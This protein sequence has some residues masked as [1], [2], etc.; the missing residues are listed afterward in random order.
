M[1]RVFPIGQ[2]ESQRIHNKKLIFLARFGN[3]VLTLSLVSRSILRS[4]VIRKACASH[5]VLVGRCLGFVMLSRKDFAARTDN[6]QS[7][8][9]WFDWLR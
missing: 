3:R 8:G 2:S 4:A 7:K 9:D 6:F 5:C 1:T